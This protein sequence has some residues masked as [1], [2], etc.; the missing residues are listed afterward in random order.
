MNVIIKRSDKKDK[1]YKAI[2][3]DGTIT[4]FGAT[5]YSDYTQHKDPLR[6]LRYLARHKKNESWEDY[7]SPGSLSRYIL[8]NKPTLQ[9]SINDYKKRFNLTTS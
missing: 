8:W 4:Y 5:G 3:S 6:K 9:E 2:F 7:K 1:K